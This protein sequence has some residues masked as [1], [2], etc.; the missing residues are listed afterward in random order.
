MPEIL[1]SHSLP[2]S[3]QAMYQL[4]N[5]IERYPEFLPGCA[6]AQILSQEEGRLSAKVTLQKGP[7][8]LSFT[9]QN[10]VEPN[11]KIKMDLLEGPFEYLTG[12]WTFED[13]GQGSLLKLM[14]SFQLKGGLFQRMVSPLFEKFSDQLLSVFVQRAHDIYG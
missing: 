2:Y 13:E 4:V 6:A 7:M 12:E 10:I 3:A 11:Q 1:Q 14:L 5:D 8:A 9:T